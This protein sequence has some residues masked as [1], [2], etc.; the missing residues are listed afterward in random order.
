[1]MDFRQLSFSEAPLIKTQP[2]GQKSQEHLDFQKSSESSAVSYPKGLP[3]A[4]Q[5]AKGATVE[6]VDGNVYIDFFGGAGVMNVGHTNPSVIEAA[7]KQMSDVT[8]SLD[9]P[10]P[11]RRL[12]VEILLSVLPGSL[13]PK[14]RTA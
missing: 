11:A 10:N 8:H 4:V 5:R 12:L 14:I 9:I 6:D 7:Q 3:M 13:I 1:M 2:P